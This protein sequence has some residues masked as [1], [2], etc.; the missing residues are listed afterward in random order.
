MGTYGHSNI[1]TEEGSRLLCGK[2]SLAGSRGLFGV[3]ET[4][5]SVQGD[6]GGRV[7]GSKSWSWESCTESRLWDQQC[8][9]WVFNW[10]WISTSY[11]RLETKPRLFALQT[12]MQ[13]SEEN[14]A[15]ASTSKTYKK[16]IAPRRTV[17]Q[18]HPPS[19]SYHFGFW[20]IFPGCK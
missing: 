11:P 9:S 7:L 5:L 20:W 14:A 18:Y 2:G 1:L 16:V 17:S 3:V 6:K 4:E 15:T 19:F 8:P 12:C 10:V 13:S